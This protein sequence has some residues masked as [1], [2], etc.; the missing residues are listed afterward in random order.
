[1]VSRKTDYHDNLEALRREGAKIKF[2]SPIS[3]KKIPKCSTS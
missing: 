1:M 3:D 2:F